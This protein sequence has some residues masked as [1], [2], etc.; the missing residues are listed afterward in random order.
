MTTHRDTLHPGRA[1][2]HPLWLGALALLVL[3][4]HVWKA[5]WPGLV[6]GK[7]SDFA[8][9]AVAPGVLAALLM[10]RSRA[11]VFGAHLAVGA[12]FAAI[13][14][15]PA[16]ARAWEALMALGP[17]PWAVTVDPT[18]LV[19]LG[20]LAASW[21]WLVPAMAR[22]LP[23]PRPLL[24]T[25]ALATGALACMATSPPSPNPVERSTFGHL[26]LVNDDASSRI[27]RVRELR[28]DLALDCAVV[29]QDPSG[30]L[31]REHF[32]AAR[33]YD[34][35]PEAEL[36]ISSSVDDRECD[37][38]LIDGDGLAMR[39]VFFETAEFPVTALEPGDPAA[40]QIVQSSAE[41]ATITWTGGT[42]LAPP[43]VQ[44]L[45]PLE[46]A[47]RVPDAGTQLVWSYPVPLGSHE[48]V[49][50]TEAPDGCSALDLVAK[51]SEQAEPDRWYFCGPPGALPFEAGELIDFRTNSTASAES[52][53]LGGE[54]ATV[55]ARVGASLPFGAG[56]SVSLE[57]AEGCEPY[58]EPECAHLVTALGARVGPGA[59]RPAGPEP[60]PVGGTIPGTLYLIRAFDAHGTLYFCTPGLTAPDRRIEAIWIE[61]VN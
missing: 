3:N 58:V 13:N 44:D 27:V 22:P 33:V 31:S 23:S 38:A 46:P 26:M 6:T 19:G 14:V 35:G 24:Q 34:L 48:L 61:E 10:A 53:E 5:A 11:A 56:A 12:V 42:L 51:G 37:A 8:G 47:C 21:V 32:A 54:G 59:L 43:P 1:L 30:R 7:L 60:I 36:P 25:A 16:A 41:V 40:M 57:V 50:L 52:I 39:L 45:E 29:A 4:D 2:L 18:D 55:F 17:L 20:G 9:L 28:N 15:W 49:A